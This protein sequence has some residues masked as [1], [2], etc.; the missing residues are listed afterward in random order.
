MH[1]YVYSSIIYN[2][3]DM[4][5]A[6]VCIHRWMDKEDMVCTHTQTH[7]HTQEYYSAIKK[8]KEWTSALCNNMDG[9]R[10]YNA[11]WNKSEKDKYQ[12]ISLV[13]TI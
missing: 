2:S 3:Q 13:G 6:Q 7:T 5:A 4:E 9:A 12:L 8:N 1:P 11:K 10:E